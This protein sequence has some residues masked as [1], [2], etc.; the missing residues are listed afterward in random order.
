MGTVVEG[1][2]SAVVRS[3][4]RACPNRRVGE[5]LSEE[6]GSV[7]CRGSRVQCGRTPE[8]MTSVGARVPDT[9]WSHPWVFKDLYF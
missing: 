3:S 6:V 5:G 2:D 7:P 4:R 9:G 1:T 8:V